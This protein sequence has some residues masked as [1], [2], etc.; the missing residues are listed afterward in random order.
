MLVHHKQT[1]KLKYVLA[2]IL[3]VSGTVPFFLKI[4]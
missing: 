2:D 3:Q 1:E 4:I